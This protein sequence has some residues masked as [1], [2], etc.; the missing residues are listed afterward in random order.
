MLALTCVHPEEIGSRLDT[1]GLV[2]G[3]A[4]LFLSL[5]CA[6]VYAQSASLQIQ[7]V[8]FLAPQLQVFHFPL[9]CSLQIY[10]NYCCAFFSVN[11]FQLLNGDEHKH[12]NLRSFE[13]NIN[14]S[15]YLIYRISFSFFHFLYFNIQYKRI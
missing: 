7:S 13:N 14:I 4:S 8:S 10:E 1:L 2:S 6:N 12:L 9:D 5:I 11:I 15:V 3:S